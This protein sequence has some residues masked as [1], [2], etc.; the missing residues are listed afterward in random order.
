MRDRGEQQ[1]PCRVIDNDRGAAE[2]F[3]CSVLC[4]VGKVSATTSLVLIP[5]RTCGAHQKYSPPSRANGNTTP[6]NYQR[7]SGASF[8][9]LFYQVQWMESARRNVNPTYFL[10]PSLTRGALNIDISEDGDELYTTSPRL[11][12]G[13]LDMQNQWKK[14]LRYLKYLNRTDK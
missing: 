13:S 14:G 12:R 4:T 1:G 3:H 9:A 8:G 6:Y 5:L 2:G 11:L 7:G 10:G